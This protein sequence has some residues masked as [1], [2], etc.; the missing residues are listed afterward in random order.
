MAGSTGEVDRARSGPDT[1]SARSAR[2]TAFNAPI[3]KLP[4][5]A[6]V[7]K[8]LFGKRPPVSAPCLEP[9]GKSTPE[10]LAGDNTI[11]VVVHRSHERGGHHIREI[12]PPSAGTASSKPAAV[13]LP[14]GWDVSAVSQSGTIGLYQGRQFVSLL[15]LNGE[16]NYKVTIR[17]RKGR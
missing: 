6:S 4:G 15:N 2:V 5:G 9:R 1:R 12:E 14:A 7:A 8:L 3:E 10:L 17:A 16:N 11:L 13:L